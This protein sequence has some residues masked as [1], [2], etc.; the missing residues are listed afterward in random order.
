MTIERGYSA[1]PSC[2]V[3]DEVEQSAA[4]ENRQN[5]TREVPH[6]GVSPEAAVQPEREKREAPNGQQPGQRL[7]VDGEVLGAN[8]PVESQPECEI[9]GRR[10]QCEIED[11][12]E[13][14]AGDS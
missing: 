3:D 10:D 9:R 13:R 12:D 8:V 5:D 6:A 7:N 11:H 2:T 14:Q 4:R 1:G